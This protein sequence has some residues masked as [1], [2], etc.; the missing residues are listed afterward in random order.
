MQK[1]LLTGITFFVL[2]VIVAVGMPKAKAQSAT[3]TPTPTTAST[4]SGTT[5]VPKAPATG[6]AVR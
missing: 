4:T 6:Q 5:S 3:N 2:S 1:I